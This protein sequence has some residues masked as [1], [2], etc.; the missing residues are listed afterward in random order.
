MKPTLWYPRHSGH[1]L[2]RQTAV[3]TEALFCVGSSPRDCRSH[4]HLNHPPSEPCFFQRPF[5]APTEITPKRF[6][7]DTWLLPIWFEIVPS[8]EAVAQEL[9]KK[10]RLT[11]TQFTLMHFSCSKLKCLSN[12]FFLFFIF[13]VGNRKR[14]RWRIIWLH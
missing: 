5:L 9:W 13:L 14:C 8:D 2:C 1:C 7:I 11:Y 3:L 6:S 12:I 10:R 4:P